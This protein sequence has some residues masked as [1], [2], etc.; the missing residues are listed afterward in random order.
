[1]SDNYTV[2]EVT[3][4]GGEAPNDTYYL[5]PSWGNIQGNESW[6]DFTAP[7]GTANQIFDP[8]DLFGF[9]ASA[10]TA[11]AAKA[12]A[13][14]ALKAQKFL[15][16]QYATLEAMQAPYVEGGIR[17]FGIQG[18]LSG[19]YG[20]QAKEIAQQNYM[21]SLQGAVQAGSPA[22][23]QGMPAG[24]ADALAAYGTGVASQDYDNYFNRLGYGAGLG[25]AAA[26]ALGGV[27]V[28]L[29]RGIAGAMQARGDAGTNNMLMQQQIR[30]GTLGN[31]ATLG[32]AAIQGYGNY[33]NAQNTNKLYGTQR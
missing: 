13:D 22:G 20:Q 17:S 24:I 1:M 9:Q 16:R 8:L 5:S 4:S 26:S 18:A 21:Q 10:D 12:Q 33:Q 14:A 25:Q 28:D 23:F 31:L 27:N 6:S 7:G 19:L 3:D 15:E 32:G 11:A 29:S 30:G 2:S